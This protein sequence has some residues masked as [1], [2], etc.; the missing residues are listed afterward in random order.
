MKI[1]F[2]VTEF[3]AVSE[4]FILNQI[5]GLIDLGHEVEIFAACN[6]NEDKIQPDVEKYRLMDR[7][8][9]F[10]MPENKLLRI[11]KAIYDIPAN[12]HRAPLKILRSL[13]VFKYGNSALS[14]TLFYALLCFE[15]R[16]FDIIHCHFGHN[17]IVGV[18]LKRL[19]I[20]G[21]I[22]TTFYGNDLTSF[23]KKYGNKVYNCLINYGD[24]FLP[25]CEYFKTKLVDLGCEPKKII[26]HH[27]GTDLDRFQFINKQTGKDEPLVMLTVGRLVE[28]KGH[29]YAL[30][31]LA[32]IIKDHKKMNY[33][34]AGDGPLRGELEQLAVEL[35]IKDHVEFT[36]NAFITKILMRASSFF[37]LPSV[38]AGDGDQEGTPAVLIEAQACGLPVISTFHSGIPEVIINGKS[39]FLVPEKD[40]DALAE[41]IEYLIEH[42]E[43]WFE[44]GRA[45][46][47][48]VEKK[49]DI[50]TLNK[51]LEQ[52]YERFVHSNSRV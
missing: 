11:L 9:F 19:G 7:V 8:H 24:L 43:M 16:N 37:V 1:A 22:I 34:I 30:M 42:E 28:K 38:T 15:G 49:Y 48:F 52:I 36:G 12:F 23:L 27:I 4:T 26:V 51:K 5:T 25:I 18:N 3:P 14:L 47:E 46:R 29:K 41:R 13:N 35:D 50:K 31:A 6:P 21:K 44:I 33:I 45:G 10:H 17:G 2:L 39:G 32:K 40:V 20:R